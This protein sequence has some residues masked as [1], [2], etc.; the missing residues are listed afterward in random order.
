MGC[1]AIGGILTGC[2]AESSTVSVLLRRAATKLGVESR[3][4]LIRAFRE[5]FAG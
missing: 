4:A 2:L 5:G 3:I 1:G